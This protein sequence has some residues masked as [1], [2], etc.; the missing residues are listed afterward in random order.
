[1]ET[2]NGAAERMLFADLP[3]YTHGQRLLNGKL[4]DS[5]QPAL[6]FTSFVTIL[7]E[8]VQWWN[9]E[10]RLSG[11]GKTP[12]ESWQEDLTPIDW[13][14]AEDLRMF[15]LEEDGRIR[16]ITTKG[17]QKGRGRFYTAAWMTGRAG[18]SVKVRYMP[19]H[20]DQIEVFDARTGRYLGSAELSDKASP[21]EIE[22]MKQ[23]RAR[24]SQQ[25]RADLKAAEKQRRERY[26]AVSNAQQPERLGSVTEAEA[27]A[28]TGSLDDDEMARIA[29]KRPLT[30]DG[31][32]ST[33]VL[34]GTAKRRRQQNKHGGQ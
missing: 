26:A 6:P 27:Q 2:L 13:V 34:P 16:K 12:A 31:L 30:T 9:T 10:H 3:R 15:T 22:E 23:A 7:L 1:M 20:D 25:L 17:I 24:R 5:D 4:V 19:H 18:D 14:P 29:T 28:E 8:W 33:W 21:A 11:T 32:P